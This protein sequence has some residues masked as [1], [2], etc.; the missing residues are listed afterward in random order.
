M[1]FKLRSLVYFLDMLLDMLE[2]LDKIFSIKFYISTFR[3]E[4][5]SPLAESKTTSILGKRIKR[6]F[7]ISFSLFLV[8]IP[9]F[10]PDLKNS[11]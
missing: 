1:H 7:K 9:N 10:P 5:N 3:G 11:N 8:K 4:E 2:M 6:E